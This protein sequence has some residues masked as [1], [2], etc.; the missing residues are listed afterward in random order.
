MALKTFVKISNV[1]N[2][3]DARY[4]AGMGVDLIGFSIDLDSDFYVSPEKAVEIAE[5][6]AGVEFVAEFYGTDVN[7]L[8]SRIADYPVSY[9]EYCRPELT[10]EILALGYSTIFKVSVPDDFKEPEFSETIQFVGQ[11]VDFVLLQGIGNFEDDG[12]VAELKRYCE[13][14]SV[15]LGGEFSSE[16]ILQLLEQIP[17]K[18]IALQGSEE[19]KPGFKDF[20]EL[21]D[22]LETL[23]VDDLE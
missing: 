22:I 15:I 3:S 6:L 19:I 12:V 17:A 2:L 20:D 13:Q 14:Y 9:V 4:C 10:Y 21:A 7:S 5:W 23:E 1:T 8:K 11:Q 18:G 16:N